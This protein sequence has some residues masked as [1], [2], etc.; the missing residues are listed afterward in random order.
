VHCLDAWTAQASGRRWDLIAFNF[1]LHEVAFDTERISV[2]QYAANLANLTSRLV[3]LQKRDGTRL[4]WVS[5]TPVPALPP[6][7]VGGS[8]EKAT[9]GCLHPPRYDADVV[10]Y[11]AAAASVVATANLA[12]G[13]HIATL[14]LYDLVL[15]RCGG[16]GYVRCDGVQ[17]PADVH[18]TEAGSRMIADA[19]IG[20]LR[21]AL[22]S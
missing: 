22:A 2:E 9:S 18:F 8:C 20:A 13:V 17:Q 21:R 10:L 12:H 4:L 19:L 6:Y 14:D 5:T 1:G 16:P 11:N 15:W 3:A 7:G